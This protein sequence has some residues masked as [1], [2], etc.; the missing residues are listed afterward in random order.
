MAMA[1]GS[2]ALVCHAAGGCHTLD[3]LGV[4]T[5]VAIKLPPIGW[6]VQSLTGSASGYRILLSLVMARKDKTQSP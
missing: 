1:A 5:K 4:T 3:F 2:C 6:S